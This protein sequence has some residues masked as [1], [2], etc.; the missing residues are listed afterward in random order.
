V[1]EI[2]QTFAMMIS[3]VEILEELGQLR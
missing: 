2:N 1:R 3:K